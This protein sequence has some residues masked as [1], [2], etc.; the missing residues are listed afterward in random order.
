[1][2]DQRPERRRF[3]FGLRKL[4]LWTVVV[5]VLLGSLR[6]LGLDTVGLVIAACWVAITAAIR[7]AFGSTW[8]H[9]VSSAGGSA[10]A[11]GLLFTGVIGATSIVLFIILAAGISFGFVELAWFGVDWFD[12]LLRTKPTAD[13]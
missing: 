4:L 10:L 6:A 12:E 11:L 1:M 7:G 9:V 3:Q 2:R 8:A 13:D 5:A